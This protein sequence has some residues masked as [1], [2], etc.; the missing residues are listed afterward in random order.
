MTI[1]LINVFEFWWF[2]NYKHVWKL[3]SSNYRKEHFEIVCVNRYVTAQQMNI[4]NA[5]QSVIT[6]TDTTQQH[7]LQLDQCFHTN[8]TLNIS[9]RAIKCESRLIMLSGKFWRF[10][11]F[12]KKL[13]FH[14][15]RWELCVQINLC[16]V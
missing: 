16:A 15:N 13:I 14:I 12:W 8:R 1:Q 9:G 2:E 6:T 7:H 4:N 11:F 3:C 10:F 5:M